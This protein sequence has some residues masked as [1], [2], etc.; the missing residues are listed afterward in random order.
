[1]VLSPSLSLSFYSHLISPFLL[2]LHSPSHILTTL[3]RWLAN[4]QKCVLSLPWRGNVTGQRPAK[5]G[6]HFPA[7]FAYTC[8][9]VTS[10]QC[11]TVSREM[12][13]IS[14]G[15]WGGGVY[16]TA[17]FFFSQLKVEGF[18]KMISTFAAHWNHLESFKKSCCPFRC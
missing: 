9:C 1:M 14:L 12:S 8:G 11:R 7:L 6:L 10:S 15:L 4:H 5:Q 13:V 17:S 16:S 2:L 3:P 18:V